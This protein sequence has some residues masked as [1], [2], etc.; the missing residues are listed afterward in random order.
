[1][2]RPLI[3]ITV[4]AAVGALF[5]VSL[6]VRE[7]EAELVELNRQITG[8]QEALHVLRAEWSFLNHPARLR[9][10]NGRYLD[11][12]PVEGRQLGALAQV[13]ER[14]PEAEVDDSAPEE[15]TLVAAV[16][17]APRR[18]PASPPRINASPARAAVAESSPRAARTEDPAP[19]NEWEWETIEDA[20]ADVLQL[21]ALEPRE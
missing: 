12:V 7:L 6:E 21:S 2:I 9:R 11:L 3:V 13:P 19:T 15:A 1:M 18:K 20:I 8:E 10:L 16:T 5:Y 14:P 17:V 4:S